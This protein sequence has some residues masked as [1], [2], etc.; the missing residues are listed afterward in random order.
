[1]TSIQTT[2]SSDNPSD[3]VAAERSIRDLMGLLALPSLWANRDGQTILQIMNEA[4]ER[5]VVPLR[6]SYAKVVLRPGTP[7]LALLRVDGKA[8]NGDCLSGWQLAEKQWPGQQGLNANAFTAATPLGEM[9]VV[10]FNIAYPTY[11][12]TIWFGSS[13]PG[14][15]SNAQLAFLRAATSLAANGLQTARITQE[16]EEAIRAKDEFLAM[17]G[18]ELRNPLAPISAAL[19]LIKLKNNSHL[20]YELQIIER[21][22]GHLGQLVNDLLDVTRITRGKIELKKEPLNLITALAL[23]VESVRPAIDER[24]HRLITSFSGAHIPILGDATRLK[25]VFSNLLTNATKYTDPGGSIE[26][27]TH[28]N[29][30]TVSVSIRD[31]GCGISPQLFPR[32]FKIFEQGASS[33]ARSQGGLGIGLALV[34]NFVEL[35]GGTVTASSAGPGQGSTFTVSLPILK[36]DAATESKPEAKQTQPSRPSRLL[37]VDDNVDALETLAHLIQSHGYEVKSTTNPLEALQIAREFHPSVA[38]LDI[39]LPVMNG[40]KLAREF[41]KQFPAQELKL[42]ALTGYGQPGDRER[43][44][45]AGFDHHL[46]KPVVFS[47]LISALNTSEKSG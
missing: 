34:K 30:D 8:V 15:P 19:D 33:M 4:I 12:G 27:I 47:D 38:V 7:A 44:K 36:G 13:D 26:V 17:L 21:Q 22:V 39:G 1:M 25:Q 6:F 40:Y 11:G 23:S 18:H 16:R 9:R 31:T 41:R 10:R 35:H 2:G 14:F 28:V 5:I 3:E 45:S 46:V 37:I 24:N 42:I 20:T 32:L 29:G 43:A